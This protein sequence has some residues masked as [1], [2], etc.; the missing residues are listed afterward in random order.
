[1]ERKTS[2]YKAFAIAGTVLCGG[3]AAFLTLCYANPT[4]LGLVSTSAAGVGLIIGPL[5]N[6]EMS[7]EGIGKGAFWGAVVGST[8]I[9]GLATCVGGG[10][11]A[12]AGA[13]IACPIRGIM[14]VV[15][16][17]NKSATL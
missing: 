16:R 15:T 4:F 6:E 14:K 7:W 13:A 12:I 3:S 10:L 2:L 17:S 11:G 5:I 8:G 1:M 9:V